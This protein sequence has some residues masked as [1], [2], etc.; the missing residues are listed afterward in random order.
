M[1]KFVTIIIIFMNF[2]IYAGDDF[3]AVDSSEF[4]ETDSFESA[5]FNQTDIA[6]NE[7]KTDTA[8]LL[9]YDKYLTDDTV[10]IYITFILLVLAVIMVHYRLFI[11]RKLFLIISIGYFGFYMG[12][13]SC[14]IGAFLKTVSGYSITFYG[15]ISFVIPLLF[16]IVKGRVFCG[17][18]C[19]IGALQEILAVKD[20][21]FKI[22]LRVEKM[23][24]YLRYIILFSIIAITLISGKFIGQEIMPFKAIFNFKGNIVQVLLGILFVLISIFLYRPFCKFICPYSIVLE[25]AAKLPFNKFK[26]SDNGCSSCGLCERNCNMNSI[27]N[28]KINHSKCIVCGECSEC[29]IKMSEK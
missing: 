14:S 22:P 25:I 11:I 1:K 24:S 3:K 29:C 20:K 13:C 12:G 5:E 6:I 21:L 26:C 28:N 7:K 15:V 17:W 18:V 4:N 23:L 2:V 10:K 27:V 9:T 19:P 16:A 8:N